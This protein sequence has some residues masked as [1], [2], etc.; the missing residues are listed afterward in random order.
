MIGEGINFSHKSYAEF[1][2]TSL[3]TAKPDLID[4]FQKELVHKKKFKN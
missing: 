1:F 2:D 4:L 3:T